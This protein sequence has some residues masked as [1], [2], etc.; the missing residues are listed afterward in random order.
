MHLTLFFTRGNSLAT[1]DQTGSLEREV[2]LYQRLQTLGVQVSFITYGGGRERDFSTRL[3]G[4]D[5]L[6]NRHDLTRPIYETLVPLLHAAH[7]RTSD[8]FKTNQIKG[9]HIALMA[10]WLWRKPVIVRCGY[11]WASNLARTQLVRTKEKRKVGFA[12]RYEEIIF[13]YA[14]QIV[15]TTPSMRDDI[16]ARQ[17]EI[18]NRVTVIPNFVDTVLFFPHINMQQP[19]EI[20]YVGRISPEKNLSSLLFAMHTLN[21]SLTL[22]GSGPLETTLRQ[23]FAT[24]GERVRWIGNVPNDEIPAYLQ[25][26][27]LFVLPSQFEGH[28]KAL[29]EAMSCGLA[30]LGTDVPGIR[31]LIHH[32]ETGWLCPPDVNSLHAAIEHLLANPTLRSRLGCNARQYVLENFSLDRI[33]KMELDLMLKQLPKEFNRG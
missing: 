24:L 2:A 17:P 26:A 9:A 18:G 33:V 29:L 16:I 12:T 22:I 3:P 13:R 6:C 28:P 21:A 32:N 30:V 23:Q 8:V 20:V 7:L 14:R 10:G 27:S 1:W 5:I 31:D 19:R 11:L 4:I 15:V 25:N